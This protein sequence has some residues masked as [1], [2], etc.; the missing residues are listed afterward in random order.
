MA[1]ALSPAQQ[2]EYDH[3][4]SFLGT[5]F[6]MLFPGKFPSEAHPIRVLDRTAQQ[7]PSRALG[8]LRAAVNDLVEATQHAD[9]GE[10]AMLEAR[11]AEAGVASLRSIRERRSQAIFKILNRGSI[12]DDDEWRVISGAI[13]D[14][15]DR[16]LTG[17]SRSLAN[18]LLGRYESHK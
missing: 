4:R 3:L 13:A 12:D 17:T 1:K 9:G 11:L 10:L 5:L 15:E 6:D 8:G 2:A 16:V 7:S 14:Q 18:E